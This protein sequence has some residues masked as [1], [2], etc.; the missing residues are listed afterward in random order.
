MIYYENVPHH[1]TEEKIYN[2][3]LKNLIKFH[4]YGNWILYLSIHIKKEQRNARI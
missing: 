4:F 1:V 3:K 2:S